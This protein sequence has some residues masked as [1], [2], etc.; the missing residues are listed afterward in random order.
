MNDL[1]RQLADKLQEA[2]IS[3]VYR[4]GSN[5]QSIIF[6]P[7]FEWN[8]VFYEG[9]GSLIQCKCSQQIG[10]FQLPIGKK[11]SVD[12]AFDIIKKDHE[13][14]GRIN[15]GRKNKRTIRKVVI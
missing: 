7:H 10:L 6:A 13:N 12:D 11:V 4:G 9:N 2:K 8:S 5:E 14:Y 15:N 3:Y 1:L